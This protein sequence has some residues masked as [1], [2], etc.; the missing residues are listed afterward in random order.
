M[1]HLQAPLYSLL[2]SITLVFF[3]TLDLSAGNWPSWRGD[4]AGSGKTPET[5]LPLEW[6]QKKNVVWRIDLPDRGNS[7]PAIWGDKVFVP[8]AIKDQDFRGL[9]C[10]NKKDG[11]LLWK[12]GIT[13]NQKEKTHPSNPYCSASPATDGERVIVSY[14][15]AGLYC[16]DMDGKEIWK[17]D[18]GPIHHIWGNAASPVIYN[19]LCIYYHGPDRANGLLTALDKKTG[20]PVWEFKE[21]Q[22]KPV[23]RTDGFKG[24]DEGGVIGSWSTPIIVP[25]ES[26]DQLVMSFPTQVKAFNPKSG[27]ELWTSD[28]LNPLIYSS[29]MFGNNTIVVMGGFYGNTVT[30]KTGGKGDVTQSERI[31]HKVRD[32]GGIG[33]GLIKGDM[34]YYQDGS[35]KLYCSKL[36]SGKVLWKQKL[37]GK[38]RTWGSLLLS[39]DHFYTLSQAGETVVFKAGPNGAYEQVAHNNIGEK[40]NSSIAVSDGQLFIRT[41]KGLWCIG[42]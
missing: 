42:K 13:Y 17:R 34:V 7:T 19:D 9:M 37:P 24:R 40:T 14:G 18:F 6:D 28:G 30:V 36:Q 3:S 11:R 23:K 2:L 16:Y 4:N 26:G 15:S 29:P 35:G 1:K 39:G 33:T 41:W 25:S 5:N 10:L 27:K 20:E 12:K 21:P 8:Q 38:A 32:Q 22:W 31:W